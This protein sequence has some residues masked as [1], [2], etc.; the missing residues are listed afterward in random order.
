M[1]VNEISRIAAGLASWA[2]GAAA[3]AAFTGD[4]PLLSAFAVLGAA[5]LVAVCVVSARQ[6]GPAR[7]VSTAAIAAS[8]GPWIAL[9]VDAVDVPL[10]LSISVS[11]TFVALYLHAVIA[12]HD[13]HEWLRRLRAVL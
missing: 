6:L 10:A 1:S 11:I 3:W 12:A 7:A 4:G 5:G 2:V 9:F 13:S 8:T